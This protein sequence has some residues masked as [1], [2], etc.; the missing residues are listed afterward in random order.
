MATM[1]NCTRFGRTDEMPGEHRITDN[2]YRF[3][4]RLLAELLA[5]RWSEQRTYFATRHFSIG[6][7]Q[8]SMRDPASTLA[9][10][11]RMGYRGEPKRSQC[12]HQ[13]SVPRP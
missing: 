9:R 10:H 11:W 2:T 6:V 1:A 7:Q 13:G 5:Q 8:V 4:H 12:L 3:D